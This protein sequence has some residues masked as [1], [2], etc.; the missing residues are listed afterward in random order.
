M[1][2]KAMLN[3]TACTQ[4]KQIQHCGS[5][6]LRYSCTTPIFSAGRH[7]G[8]VSRINGVYRRKAQAFIRNAETALLS[9]A[10]EGYRDSVKNGYPIHQ[11]ETVLEFAVTYNQDC[12]LSLYT[13]EYTYTGGAHGGTVRSSETWDLTGG[14]RVPLST[15]FP[16]NPQYLQELKAEI[17]RQIGADSSAYFENYP[18]LVEE[19]FNPKSFYL[20]PDALAVYFQQYDIAPYAT[21]IPVFLIPMVN[22]GR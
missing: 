2:S 3:V 21:G 7:P 12:G 8:A 18:Q 15:F 1:E 10:M 9:S 16:G 22:R 14:N 13:D 4:G 17:I 5:P 6:V 19:T 20:Q 11:Y